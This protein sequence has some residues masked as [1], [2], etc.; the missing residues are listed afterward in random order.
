MAH[1]QPAAVDALFAYFRSLDGAAPAEKGAQT[2]SAARL[3]TGPVVASGGAPGAL[4]FAPMSI[5]WGI[6]GGPPYPKGVSVPPNRYYTDYGLEFPYIVSPPWSSIVA[7]DL[8]QG[9]IKWRVPLGEDAQAAAE[10]AKNT[11]VF[12]G[13]ERHGP[14]V[15]AT[16]LLFIA[17][18]DGKVRAYDAETGEVLWTAPLPAGSEG[19]PSMYEVNGRQ[20]LV[21]CATTPISPGGRRDNTGG[22]PVP[23]G[24]EASTSG[25]P[26][27][28]VAFALPEAQAAK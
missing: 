17:A 8:N 22:T 10:G 19:I 23:A 9:A 16:G 4:P 1:L 13:G 12:S 24:S 21:V 5:P 28:Y 11:G 20:F 6:M 18:E 2:S 15:T 25:L 26:R 3:A 14:I 27:G 7:F